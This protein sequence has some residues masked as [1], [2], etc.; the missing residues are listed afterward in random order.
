MTVILPYTAATKPRLLVK[1]LTGGRGELVEFPHT[2]RRLNLACPNNDPFW[3]A[4]DAVLFSSHC[5]S[6]VPLGHGSTRREQVLCPDRV[7]DVGLKYYTR[8]GHP[9]CISMT[10]S[11]IRISVSS[12]DMWLLVVPTSKVSLCSLFLGG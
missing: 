12:A 11:S 3:A 5:Q 10:S 6:D 1:A 4:Q 2:M 7:V 9:Y 8:K